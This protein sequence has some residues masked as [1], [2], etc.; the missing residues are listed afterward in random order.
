MATSSAPA[1]GPITPS[2]SATAIVAANSPTRVSS[3]A[4]AAASAPVKATWLRASPAN[5]C[6][7]STTK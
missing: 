2:S 4:A 5:T 1:R 3:P 7:R 6:A